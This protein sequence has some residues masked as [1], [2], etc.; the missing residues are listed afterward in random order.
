VRSRCDSYGSD[1]ERP[2]CFEVVSEHDLSG[3]SLKPPAITTMANPPIDRTQAIKV[4]STGAYR[5]ESRRR[6]YSSS[7][8]GTIAAQAVPLLAVG[9]VTKLTPEMVRRR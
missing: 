1:H 5:L 9:C 7:G 2:R 8:S 4:R 3:S 6:C